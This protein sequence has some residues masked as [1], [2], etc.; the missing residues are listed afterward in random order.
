MFSGALAGYR[1]A[2]TLARRIPECAGRPLA[3][4]GGRLVGRFGRSRRRQVGRHVRRV[5]GADLP[6]TALRRATGRVFASYADYWYRSLRLPAMDTAE[7]G[8]RFSID[9]YRHLEEARTVGPGPIL[10][11]PHLGSWECAGL[12]LARV[13]RVPV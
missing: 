8:R 2:S 5:Q 11:L 3:R 9:G 13:M 1:L 7:L 4:A 12:W 10:A 6:A